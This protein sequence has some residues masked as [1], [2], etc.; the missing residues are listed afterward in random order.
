MPN[1]RAYVLGEDDHIV[2]RV[3]LTCLDD[4]TA[5][6]HAKRLVDHLAIELWDGARMIA[7]FE[8]TRQ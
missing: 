5:K 2:D 6:E 4:E 1:Y 3:D 7:K 8:P